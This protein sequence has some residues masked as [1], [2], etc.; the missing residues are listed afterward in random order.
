MDIQKAME[1]ML[2][3]QARFDAAMA[4]LTAYQIEAE[5][6]HLKEMADTRIR[7][8][9][10]DQEMAE[11]RAELRRAEHMA[12]EEFRRERQR[13]LEIY[14]QQTARHEALALTMQD[15]AAAHKDLAAAQKVTEEKLQRVLDRLDSRS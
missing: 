15:I 8:A 9:R 2:E 5:A 4:K 7:D 12:I 13:R 11:L 14:Q 10:H 1:F 3:S 6:R